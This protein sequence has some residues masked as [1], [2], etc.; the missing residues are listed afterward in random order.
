MFP[1]C[2]PSGRLPH[3][4]SHR[5]IAGGGADRRPPHGTIGGVWHARRH[6]C[7]HCVARKLLRR[8]A[9]RRAASGFCS[10][11]R[12]ARRVAERVSGEGPHPHPQVERVQK[13]SAGGRCERP[14]R[15][16]RMALRALQP[17]AAA[18]GRMA[19]GS[20]SAWATGNSC[21]GGGTAGTASSCA[22]ATHGRN[23]TQWAEDACPHAPCTA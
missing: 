9:G 14:P 11:E 15:R 13:E 20:L 18:A 12:F 5:P 6:S 1:P 10:E 22:A 8:F 17:A 7:A 19:A 4:G 2:S 3:H 21:A 16:H 23:P